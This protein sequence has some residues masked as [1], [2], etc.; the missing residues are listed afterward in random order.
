[1]KLAH[2]SRAFL[3]IAATSLVTSACS[4]GPNL[5]AVSGVVS[6][7]G[8]PLPY[9]LVQFQP[10]EPRG[11]YA[12]AYTNLDGRYTLQFTEAK[13]GAIVGRHEVTLRTSKRDEI[14]VEDK[15]TGLMVTPKLPENYKGNLEVKFEKDVKSGGNVIDFELAQK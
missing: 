4:R 15:K 10:V 2:R 7:D 11:T 12:S 3:L 13:K 5:G 8:I 14:Q 1:M 6:Q 9:V